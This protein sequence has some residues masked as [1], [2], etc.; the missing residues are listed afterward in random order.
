MKESA[1]GSTGL[2]IEFYKKYFKYFGRYFVD[3]L[4]SEDELPLLFKDSIVKLIPKNNN[5]VK[6]INDL[7]PISLTN[8]D[9]RIYTKVLAN[10]LRIIADKII[11]DH[12]TCSI[13]GRRIMD[14]LN[15]LR[16]VISETDYTGLELFI[17]SVDQSKAFDRIRHKYLFKLLEYINFGDFMLR[18]IKRIYDESYAKIVVNNTLCKN[19][20]IKSGLKQGCALSM[21]LYIMCIEELIFRI[22]NNNHIKGYILN[23]T[24]KHECKAGGYADDIAGLLANY[25]CIDH[26]FNEFKEWG[27]V[28]S[29][30][31]NVEKTKILALNSK[32]KEFNGIKFISTPK[33][34]GI[35]FNNKGVTINNI[36][37]ALDNIK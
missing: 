23:T 33:I 28:S 2:T 10:R 5:D 3:I 17:L 35:E 21:L 24:N 15:L 11:G 16:D 4:N 26:F 29:A 37:K 22:K 31:L 8:I 36:N 14:N 12:Q 13:K 30:I 34:L 19:I 7:K 18:G 25:E 9:Y 32:Y 20:K 6:T 1:P 27:R